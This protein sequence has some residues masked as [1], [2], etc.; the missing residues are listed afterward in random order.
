[1]SDNLIHFPNIE[2]LLLKKAAEAVEEDD[3]EEAI[4]YLEQLLEINPDHEE[5]LQFHQALIEISHK[6]DRGSGNKAELNPETLQEWR[7]GLLS[8][9]IK[10]QYETFDKMF[11]FSQEQVMSL[12]E[13]FLRGDQGDFS[14]KTKFLQECKQTCPQ[15]WTFLVKKGDKQ[16]EV[17]LKDVPL[18]KEE[19]S[20]EYM[21]PLEVLQEKAHDNPTLIQMSNEIWVY[22]LEKYYPVLPEF[23]EH[24]YW[25]AGL[26]L[27]TLKL[28]HSETLTIKQMDQIIQRYE[29][30][31][32]K[33]EE[34][35]QHLE[36]QA[37]QTLI[38]DQKG[39]CYFFWPPLELVLPLL[40]YLLR[41]VHK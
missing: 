7:E 41:E 29:I 37:Q 9:N 5:A 22:F 4:L 17:K 14:L 8:A 12:V 21:K 23:G 33:I 35:R 16:Q 25:T 32:E 26:H 2:Q 11:G 3:M 19:W 39:I 15:N 24:I 36:R 18:G 10:Q 38:L 40:F 28:I 20:E 30:P 27:Y 13:E 31:L 1:M 34:Y 6:K